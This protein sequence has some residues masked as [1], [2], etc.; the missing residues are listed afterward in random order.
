MSARIAAAQAK[1]AAKTPK[2]KNQSSA[3]GYGV[4]M[5]MV[6]DLV[7][8]AVVGLVFGLALD[9]TLGTEPW[10]VLILLSLGMIAGFRL[11]LRSASQYANSSAKVDDA[12]AGDSGSTN[13]GQDN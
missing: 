12:E 11:M 2:R 5:K 4:G 7:G 13:K 9:R 6:L 10:G 8:G 1:Q 3:S